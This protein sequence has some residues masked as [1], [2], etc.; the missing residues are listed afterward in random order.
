MKHNEA[1]LPKLV[2]FASRLKQKYGTE[3]YISVLDLYYSNENRTF[4]KEQFVEL[5]KFRL[6]LANE[7][8]KIN[9]RL[10]IGCDNIR[11]TV[12]FPDYYV[13]GECKINHADMGD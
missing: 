10:R 12:C 3:I 8:K 7:G 9:R 1:E 6:K 11:Q 4:W 2:D 13:R 5:S